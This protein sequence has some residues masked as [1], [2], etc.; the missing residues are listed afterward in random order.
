V[1]QIAGQHDGWQ[2]HKLPNPGIPFSVLR[3][4]PR[5]PRRPRGP[6]PPAKKGSHRVARILLIEDEVSIR[7]PLQIVLERAGHEVLPAANGTEA[8]QL[9]RDGGGDLV[10]TDIHMPGKDGMETIIELR[11]VAPRAPILAMSGGDRTGRSD[12]LHEAI[13]L[14]AARTISKPFTLQEMLQAVKQL[15]LEAR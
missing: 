10:I 13:L 7:R 5:R 11:Q 12:V 8:L 2:A 6:N 15:L 3:F 14:G 9:W 1:Q 4:S